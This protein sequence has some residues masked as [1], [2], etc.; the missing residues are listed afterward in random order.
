M[1]KMICT[2]QIKLP[3]YTVRMTKAGIGVGMRVSLGA[4][5]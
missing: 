1:K 2:D 5:Y 4:S 3:S